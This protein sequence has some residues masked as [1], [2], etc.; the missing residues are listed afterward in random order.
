MKKVISIL[1]A[2]ATMAF[3][4][5]AMAATD[6]DVAVSGA[7]NAKTTFVSNPASVSNMPCF[8]S[9]TKYYKQVGTTPNQTEQTAGGDTI[10]INVSN[11]TSGRELTVITYKADAGTM[12][13]STVQYINEYTTGASQ[14]ITYKVK[15]LDPGIY[16]LEINENGNKLSNFYYKI[17]S[18][19]GSIIPGGVDGAPFAYTLEDQGDGTYSVGFVGKVTVDAGTDIRIDEIAPNAGFAIKIGGRSK[20]YFGFGV[21]NAAGLGDNDNSGLSLNGLDQDIEIGGGYSVL[22]GTTVYNIPTTTSGSTPTNTGNF[23]AW[24]DTDTTN[25]DAD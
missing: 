6:G 14:T 22:F 17:G 9:S 11:L 15:D 3:A 16:K 24:V 8:R 13:E 7:R 25:N 21:T 18:V 23:K 20:Q 10:N 1:L 4:T 12:D 2:I 5:S 19:E